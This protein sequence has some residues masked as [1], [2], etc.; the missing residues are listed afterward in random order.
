MAF[1]DPNA[2]FT[3]KL[4]LIGDSSVGKSCLLTQFI[5]GIFQSDVKSTVGVGYGVKNTDLEGNKV[6]V[7]IWDTVRRT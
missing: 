6:K 2:D 7:Q 3:F 5:D 4:L 1:S